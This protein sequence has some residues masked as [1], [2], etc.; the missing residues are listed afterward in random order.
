[1]ERITLKDNRFRIIGYVDAAPN[2]DKTLRNEKFI[3]RWGNVS[4]SVVTSIAFIVMGVFFIIGLYVSYFK[5]K[6]L[7]GNDVEKEDFKEENS[8]EIETVSKTLSKPEKTISKSKYPL[9]NKKVNKED[10]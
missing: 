4:Q 9:N 1:M 6:Q 2:G 3:M 8:L 5:Q 7:V 10:E